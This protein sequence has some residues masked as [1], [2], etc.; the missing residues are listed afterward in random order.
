MGAD[1]FSRRIMQ[2]EWAT[3]QKKSFLITTAL[4]LTMWALPAP[5][6]KAAEREWEYPLTSYMWTVSL[7]GKI[8][9]QGRTTSVDADRDNYMR[10]RREPR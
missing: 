3:V 6:A 2:H 4:A 7:D 8:G 1:L 5:E 9:A 10:I